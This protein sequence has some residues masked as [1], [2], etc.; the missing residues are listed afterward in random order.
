MLISRYFRRLVRRDPSIEFAALSG[1]IVPSQTVLNVGGN[2]KAIAIPGHY[3]GWSHLLLDIDAR[4]APDIVCDA[5]RLDALQS[6]QF[7]AVYCSHNLEHYYP[8]DVRNV[9][10]G[11]LHVLKIGGF[12]EV[13]VPDVGWVMRHL[14][15]ENMDIED[16][17]YQTAAGPITVRDVI[18][19][20]SK[21]IESS[22]RDFYAHKT[23][24]TTKSLRAT[25]EAAG[26]THIFTPP[27]IHLF[28]IRAVAFKA[29]PDVRH[30]SSLGL[31]P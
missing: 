12:A 3:S 1:E 8:H 9:L 17:L 14:V 13:V 24:F 11:F 6:E 26:F 7:D 5:R 23:G 25:L 15:R 22:G 16:M 31:S 4:G 21:E 20:W 19:G 29:Q 30:F 10:R 27:P 18:Y 28:E 2:N